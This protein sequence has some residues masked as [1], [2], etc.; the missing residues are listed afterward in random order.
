MILSSN[1]SS[2]KAMRRI[3][4]N[5]K[6]VLLIHLFTIVSMQSCQEQRRDTGIVDAADSTGEVKVTSA[7]KE[8]PA[9]EISGTAKRVQLALQSIYRGDSISMRHQDRKFTYHE[10]DL[11]GDKKK[12]IF[13]GFSG[14]F[15]CSNLGCRFVLLS[16]SGHLISKFS[17]AEYPIL[18]LHSSTRGWRDM[19]VG[20]ATSGPSLHLVK[21]NGHKY[22]EG[23]SMQAE[24]SSLP[25][26][27]PHRVF[28]F[29]DYDEVWYSF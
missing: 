26:T 1:I 3:L 14:R 27:H 7:T 25:D 23:I 24:Y 22:P 12:E 29:K 10:I 8:T 18:I 17:P 15:H 13:V 11:N 9:V 5:G 20:T 16:H 2:E 28:N 4:G 19:V 6:Y 21:W